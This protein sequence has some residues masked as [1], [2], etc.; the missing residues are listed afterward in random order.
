MIWSQIPDGH[1]R[2]PTF[3]EQNPNKESRRAQLAREGHQILW[4]MRGL[5]YIARVM[6]GSFLDL[7]RR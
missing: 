4:A 6:D 7:R 3:I 5:Q 2:P 1:L